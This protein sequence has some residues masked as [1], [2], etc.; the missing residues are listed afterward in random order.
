[1]GKGNIRYFIFTIAACGGG[2][3]L[4]TS[5]HFFGP[6]YFWPFSK[7]NNETLFQNALKLF[8]KLFYFAPHNYCYFR[9]LLFYS[10]KGHLSLFFNFCT[11]LLFS[12][13][14]NRPLPAT[15]SSHQG[16]WAAGSSCTRRRAAAERRRGR[17][18]D[19]SQGA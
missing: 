16:G 6:P 15:G 17:S 1:M 12:F 9:L 13:G 10:S 4:R 8:F 5:E 14:N 18:W 11:V 3:L 2:S 19:D 7:N